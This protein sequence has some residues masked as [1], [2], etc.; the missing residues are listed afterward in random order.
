QASAP[1]I[2]S[3][4]RRRLMR[5]KGGAHGN[6]LYLW[7]RRH[8]AVGCRAGLWR[9]LWPAA[10]AHPLQARSSRPRRPAQ[11]AAQYAHRHEGFLKE[12]VTVREGNRQRKMSKRYAMLLRLVNEAVS[13][14][15]KAQAKVI[16]MA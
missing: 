16:A 15:D 3:R 8:T 4:P 13:G 14:N 11:G 12:P 6:A 5:A 7:L 9:R 2:P 10:G 1:S